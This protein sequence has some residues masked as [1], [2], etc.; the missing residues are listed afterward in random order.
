ME[1]VISNYPG[2]EMVLYAVT[3]MGCENCLSVI[4][5]F[6]NVKKKYTPQ[7]VQDLLKDNAAAKLMPNLDTRQGELSAR[8]QVVADANAIV[9]ADFLMLML[10]VNDGFDEG[11][12]ENMRK[13]AGAGYYTEAAGGNWK[14]AATMGDMMVSF[15]GAYPTELATGGMP[16]TF[17]EVVTEATGR[18]ADRLKTFNDYKSTVEKETAA[19]VMANN[20]VYKRLAGMMN[21][22]RVI[23]KKDATLRKLFSYTALAKKVAKPGK[24]GYRVALQMETSLLPVETA[25]VTAQPGNH[26]FSANKKGIVLAEMPEGTYQFVVSAPG[27]QPVAG[28]MKTHTGIMHRLKCVLKKA[29]AEE[30]VVSG[31]M[32]G[33]KEG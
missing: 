10:Y 32:S 8:G 31:D 20:G 16:D 2:K 28:E 25:T 3:E 14:S 23:F 21:D 22:G 13:V 30:M 5:K 18:F 19:K 17:A 11:A 9:C 6:A 29:V 24:T 26:S 1:K 4:D 15:I 12:I 7:W 33:V 27:W